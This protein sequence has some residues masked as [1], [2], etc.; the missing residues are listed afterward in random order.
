MIIHYKCNV[1]V[2][3]CGPKSTN[4][5]KIVLGVHGLAGVTDKDKD[6]GMDQ[7]YGSQWNSIQEEVVPEFGTFF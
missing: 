3:L 6:F 4:C 2:C 1:S 7:N 5:S